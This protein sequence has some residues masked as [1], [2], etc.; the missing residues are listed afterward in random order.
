MTFKDKYISCDCNILNNMQITS[1]MKIFKLYSIRKFK[2]FHAMS[3]VT[4]FC[5][6]IM[7]IAIFH[8]LLFIIVH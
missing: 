8:I 7:T 1:Y 4:Y 3:P 5:F 2:M 6:N